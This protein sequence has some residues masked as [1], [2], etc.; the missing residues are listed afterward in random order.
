MKLKDSNG[1]YFVAAQFQ[2]VQQVLF[3]ASSPSFNYLPSLGAASKFIVLQLAVAYQ[4]VDRIY[5][6]FARDPLTN[7][8]YSKRTTVSWW[9]CYQ[10]RSLSKF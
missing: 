9:R 3:L 8:P 6:N 10:L 2:L 1:N 5:H 7:K 4:I